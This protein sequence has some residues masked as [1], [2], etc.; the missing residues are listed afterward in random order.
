MTRYVRRPPTVDAVQ[1]TGENLDEVR[2]LFPEARPA[3]KGGDLHI[4]HLVPSAQ[5]GRWIVQLESGSVRVYGDSGFHS[6][7]VLEVER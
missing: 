5:S 4:P 7:F 6:R 2:D 3:I 1:W